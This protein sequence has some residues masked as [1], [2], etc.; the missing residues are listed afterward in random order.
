MAQELRNVPWECHGRRREGVWVGVAG[1]P[2]L[3]CLAR[4]E[5]TFNYMTDVMVHQS[6][7]A[8]CSYHI[9]I[10]SSKCLVVPKICNPDWDWSL[11]KVEA[12]DKGADVVLA[13]D[14]GWLTHLTQIIYGYVSVGMI[15]R[16]I[17]T[18][19]VQA[20]AVHY[21]TSGSRFAKLRNILGNFTP[22]RSKAPVK[23]IKHNDDNED[24]DEDDNVSAIRF[25]GI[26]AIASDIWMNHW[27]H[28]TLSIV[29]AFLNFCMTYVVYGNAAG[30]LNKKVNVENIL[31]ICSALTRVTWT[32]C[33]LHYVAPPRWGRRSSLSLSYCYRRPLCPRAASSRY[34]LG[35]G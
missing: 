30:I 7:W 22:R 35:I 16:G 5:K 25:K 23:V 26:L 8:G 1:V 9:E 10:Q 28:I 3:K 27:L 11:F 15:L 32:M 33:G 13:I 20:T 14:D 18:T 17:F 24:G 29:D 31:F 34:L 21:V 4:S 2:F 12:A 6:Y 19:L